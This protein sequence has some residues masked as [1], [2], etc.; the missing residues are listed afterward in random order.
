MLRV[1]GELPPTGNFT[2]G[3]FRHTLSGVQPL[4]VRPGIRRY[5]LKV[6][7]MSSMIRAIEEIFGIVQR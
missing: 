4:A 2:R 5:S 6:L 3:V 7:E 1:I